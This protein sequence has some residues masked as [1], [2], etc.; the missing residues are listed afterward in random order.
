M[1]DE[2]FARWELLRTFPELMRDLLR[3][4]ESADEVEEEI[5]ARCIS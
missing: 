1:E 5:S 2:A 3:E 4:Y